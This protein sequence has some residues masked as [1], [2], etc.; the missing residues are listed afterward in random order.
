MGLPDFKALKERVGID[1]VAYSLGYRINRAAGIGRYIEMILPDGHGGHTDS[2]VIRNPSDKAGQYYFRHSRMG[3]GDVLAFITEKVSLFHES[4]RNKWEIAGKVL[5]RLA[6]EPVPDITDNSYLGKIPGR[7]EFD[8][9][10]WETQ[11][12]AEHMKNGMVYLAP[13]GISKETLEAFAPHIVRIRDRKSEN[14]KGFNIGFPYR[15]PDGENVVGY[16][17]RGFAKYK[18]KA[19]GTNSSTAAWIADL[20]KIQNPFAIRNVYFAESAYDIM[21]FYQAN[22]ARLDTETSVFVSL[23]GSFSDRQVKGIMN[24]YGNARAVDCFDNDLAGQVYGIRMAGLLDNRSLHLV[25]TDMG[26][27][28][29]VNGTDILLPTGKEN[30]TELSRHVR[31][32]GR[33]KQWKPPM[34][35]KD[36]ND[37]V[38]NK[39]WKP[40]ASVNKFQ[41][42]ENLQRRRFKTKR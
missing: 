5:R 15:E 2:I 41:R 34:E 17:I 22:K 30:L 29:S 6:N 21:A 23:G 8:P 14:F 38:M 1:D 4:G 24:H 35:F 16:E 3:G 26:I 25:K 11:P 36:W 12:I 27:R 18:I 28:L 33:V 7:Q 19:A 10:R 9:E 20:S 42:D 37:V 39:P 31:F 40:Q 13:R 32:S